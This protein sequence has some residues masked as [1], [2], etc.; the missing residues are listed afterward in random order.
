[1]QDPHRNAH[2]QAPGSAGLLPSEQPV[3]LVDPDGVHRH[4]DRYPLPDGEAL[5]AAYARLVLGRRINDQ[6]NA[7]VRQGRLAVYPSSHGQEACQVAAAV[8][9]EDRDWLFPTYRDTVSVITRGVEPLQVL[10]LLRGDW[11]SGYDPYEHNTAPQATPLATQL[12]H[13]VGVAHAAKL[14][15]ED[16]VVLAMCG[17]GA[18]SEGD[19]HEALNFAAVFHVPVVFFVQNNEYAISVPLKNQS[20]APSLAH[21]AIGYGMPGER[22]DGND[23]AALLAVLGSAVDRAREGHGPSLVEAHT[24]RMQAHTNADDAT[25]Y[26]TQQDVESWVPRDPITRMRTYLRGL[27]LLD[28]D[29]EARFAADAETTAAHMREGLNTDVDPDPQELFAHVY[30]QRTTQLAEQ[31]A[32]LRD[33]LSRTDG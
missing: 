26:R 29:A 31:S 28:D 20:V 2:P 15:G 3:Q 11:H 4:D 9:L 22:V 8:V 5:L 16:T 13:A 23:L 21:K 14:K 7:L 12:L 24:Y 10:T 32:Q 27:H 17:D 1:M 25:R 18:T 33:E 6:A 30:T 19:F